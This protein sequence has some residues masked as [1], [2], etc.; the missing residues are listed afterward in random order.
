MIAEIALR[1]SGASFLS[2]G[3]TIEDILNIMNNSPGMVDVDLSD[4]TIDDGCVEILSECTFALTDYGK[5]I[6]RLNLTS[7]R[8]SVYGV[9][10]LASALL[11]HPHFEYLIISINYLSATDVMGLY[12]YLESICRKKN[13][14][15]LTI[16]SCVRTPAE[17]AQ[18]CFRKVIWADASSYCNMAKV[19]FPDYVV[20]AHA[21][22][23]SLL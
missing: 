13:V 2:V 21:K 23:Y 18:W 8:I 1:N 22:F 4:N 14:Q 19:G 9:Q 12:D 5:R 15:D 16:S 17:F 6:R 10:T 3:K 11:H 20:E 7:N